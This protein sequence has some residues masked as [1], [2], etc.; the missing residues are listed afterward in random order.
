MASLWLHGASWSWAD[1][2]SNCSSDPMV[3]WDWCP[4]LF[5]HGHFRTLE[6]AFLLW[7]RASN[8]NEW[9]ASSVSMGQRGGIFLGVFSNSFNHLRAQVHST[10][11]K[12]QWSNPNKVLCEPKTPALQLHR[13]L[14]VRGSWQGWPRDWNRMLERMMEKGLGGVDILV[15]GSRTEGLWA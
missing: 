15:V 4:Y 6:L 14:N 13:E 10:R 2:S 5:R 11:G 3:L 9:K 8:P 12:T 7:E 1:P